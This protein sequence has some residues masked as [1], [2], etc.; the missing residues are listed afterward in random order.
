MESQE[1]QTRPDNVSK[2]SPTKG[3]PMAP[4]RKVKGEKGYGL[5]FDREK[6]D[7][8]LR[9]LRETHSITESCKI[10]GISKMTAYEHKYANPDFYA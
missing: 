8:F 5:K 7:E 4:H 6:K 3:P 2:S 10:V 1:N 9:I